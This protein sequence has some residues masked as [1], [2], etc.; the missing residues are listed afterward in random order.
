MKFRSFLNLTL[1]LIGFTFF[2]Q[3]QSG[4]GINTTNPRKT[5]EVAGDVTI[6][7][8]IQVDQIRDV[9]ATDQATFLIQN[10]TEY[11]KEI[12]TA[13]SGRAIAYFQQYRLK[14]MQGD[15]VS[16]FDTKIDPAKYVV[17]II[18]AYFNVDLE[19]DTSTNNFTVPATSAVIDGTTN[20][21]HLKADYPSAKLRNA[22][23][24]GEWVINTMILS[25][26][27]SKQLE[28]QTIEMSHADNG[29]AT[30]PIID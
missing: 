1:F 23:E 28:K 15:W 21:W 30:N 6:A 16:W 9:E 2:A 10:N 17:T 8:G 14:N 7:G 5:L 26:A 29:A 22:N 19:M 25:R 3:E 12:N 24:T 18:S 27:F 11:V 13:G 20:T 4:V